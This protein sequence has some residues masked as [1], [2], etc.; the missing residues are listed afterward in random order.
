MQQRNL[1]H[2]GLKVSAIG[3]GTNQFGGKVEPGE[4]K[5]ILDAALEHEV[6]FIDTADVYQKGM[7]EETIGAAIQGRREDFVI[8]TKVFNKMGEGP[9]QKGLSRKH[10]LNGV[11]ASLKRLDTDYIDLYQMHRWDDETPIEE[12]LRTL[13]DL[14]TAGKIRYYGSSQ[15][16][17]WQLGE[18]H[19]LADRNGWTRPVSEQCHFHMLEREFLT[20]RMGA[21]ERYNLGILPYFPLAGGFLTGKYKRGEAP[22]EGS[23]GETSPYVQKYLTDANFDVLEKLSA[24]AD[25]HGHI[26]CELAH[27]WLLSFPQVSSVIS[28]ATRVEHVV[29]N[30]QGGHWELSADEIQE[31][32][33]ILGIE[34]V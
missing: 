16:N 24:W 27:A 28:G 22:P 18:I 13:D 25:D 9:N 11:E 12:S 1:G 7:S 4:V 5:N 21:A 14:V 8:A 19:W 34:S 6:T 33:T 32:N 30:S 2:S 17:A 23:R 10:I 26:V 20:E 15:F 3:L 31:V 29:A